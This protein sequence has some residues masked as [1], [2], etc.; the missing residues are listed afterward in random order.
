MTRSA[1]RFLIATIVV[2][3]LA[4]I[5]IIVVLIIAIVCMSCIV[6]TWIPH[7]NIFKAYEKTLTG[8]SQG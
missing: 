8:F 6:F 7:R 2:L 3:V 4:A 1:E 5:A